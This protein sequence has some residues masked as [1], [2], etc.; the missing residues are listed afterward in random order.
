MNQNPQDLNRVSLNGKSYTIIQQDKK[1][2]ISQSA[3]II[4]QPIARPQ[5]ET[6]VSQ[7][8]QLVRQDSSQYQQLNLSKKVE[9]IIVQYQR[10][11]SPQQPTT[12]I[13][14]I[15]QTVLLQEKDKEIQRLKADI[16]FYRN[17]LDD[18]ERYNGTLQGQVQQGQL[19]KQKILELEKANSDLRELINNLEGG[20]NIL[21]KE[22][23]NS[24]QMYSLP[25]L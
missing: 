7:P 25:P 24:K 3:N 4:Q 8:I 1:Q 22:V 2:I 13:K 17:R 21:I 11:A 10:N 5:P 14:E 18:S 9:P 6:K 23:Q 19:W 16:D 20:R 15:T 12:V